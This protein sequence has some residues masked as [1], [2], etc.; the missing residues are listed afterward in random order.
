MTVLS[1]LRSMTD[2]EIQGWLAKIGIDRVG[3]LE[4]ALLG[5]DEEVKSRVRR[6]MS[7]RAGNALR[8]DME[9]L[10]ARNIGEAE[11]SAKAKALE[12]L[13]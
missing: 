11:I 8:A 2:G 9:R 6:N 13:L 3:D 4:I 10:A 7:N 12:S 5:A 1:A